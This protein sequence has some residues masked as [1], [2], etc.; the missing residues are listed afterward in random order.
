M[1]ELLCLERCGACL[2]VFPI[3]RPCFHGQTYC[4]DACRLPAR[5]AQARLA[6]ATYQ[7]SSRGRR[8][9]SDRRRE[10][11]RRAASII[12][13]MDQG[14]ELVALS[15][16]VCLPQGPLAPMSGVLEVAGRSPD[17]ETPLCIA[18][19]FT[20]DEDPVD[21]RRGVRRD[22]TL[23]PDLGPRCAV[24]HRR[25]SVVSAWPTRRSLPEHRRDPR[26]GRSRAP[27]RARR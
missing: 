6:R 25:G 9:R 14:T 19:A 8:V 26:P 1:D 21:A 22:R 23:V 10:L 17:D 4:G 5:K 13:V 2:G 20:F 24:C 16:S 27:P 12:F 18:A 3:C 11:R 7:R 15:T